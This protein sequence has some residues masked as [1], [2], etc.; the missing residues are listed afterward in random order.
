MDFDQAIVFGLNFLLQL[1]DDM[2]HNAELSAQF[3]DLVLRLDEVLRVQ[4][5][6]CTHLLVQLL[7]LSEPIFRILNALLEIL[8][9]ELAHLELLLELRILLFC[10]CLSAA[11][12]LALLL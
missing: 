5:P 4:V 7:F 2:T 10:F 9:C 3:R 1:V 6:V 11:V 8:D 12:L